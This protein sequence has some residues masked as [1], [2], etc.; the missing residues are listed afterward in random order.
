MRPQERGVS[1]ESGETRILTR[2]TPSPGTAV[3]TEKTYIDDAF[4]SG[5]R[6]DPDQG[7]YSVSPGNLA[8]RPAAVVSAARYR[9]VS[10]SVAGPV[11]QNVPAPAA[12]TARP[13]RSA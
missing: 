4:R 6:G 2:S 10:Q 12:R 1:K 7:M 9:R 5:S 8:P 3:F 13:F 11:I